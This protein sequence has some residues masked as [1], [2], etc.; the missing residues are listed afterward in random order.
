LEGYGKRKVNIHH[1]EIMSDR[2]I[3]GNV[4]LCDFHEISVMLSWFWC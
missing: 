1:L 4:W 2:V 3:M